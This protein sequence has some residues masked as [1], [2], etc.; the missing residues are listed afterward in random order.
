VLTLLLTGS[1]RVKFSQLQCTLIAT[2]F[3]KR[4]Q[5]HVISADK[6]VR[7]YFVVHR[8][9][10]RVAM[11]VDPQKKVEG[12]H[13]LHPLPLFPPLKSRPLKSS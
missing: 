2:N 5:C 1:F 11:G 12:T 3:S 6:C 10:L 7:G 8:N 13:P 4:K 9:G